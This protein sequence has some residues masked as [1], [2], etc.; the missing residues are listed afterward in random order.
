MSTIATSGR[1]VLDLEHE[2]VGVASLT[3][4]VDVGVLE[5]S[6][7]PLAQEDGVVGDDRAQAALVL[8]H[9]PKR[10]ERRREVVGDEL[11]HALGI[12]KPVELE[13]AQLLSRR[14]Q[15]AGGVGRH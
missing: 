2:L 12:A 3:D 7:E 6:R 4:D 15:R 13:L 14:R 1:A 9:V 10:R 11:V 8:A 5:Q